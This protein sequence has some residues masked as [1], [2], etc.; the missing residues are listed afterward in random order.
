[1]T[2]GIVALVTFL[3]MLVAAVR[4]MI[5]APRSLGW[6][7]A[8]AAGLFSYH[9]LQPMSPSLTPLMFLVAGI[10]CG[11]APD[12]AASRWASPREGRGWGWAPGVALSAFVI[13][14]L[15]IVGSS[16]LDWYGHTYNSET[17][18]AMSHDLAPWRLQPADHLATYYA[19]DWRSQHPYRGPQAAALAS[20]MVSEHPWDPSS[21][22]LAA[23]IFVLLNQPDAARKLVLEQLQRFP[24]DR[25]RFSALADQVFHLSPGPSSE[26][27]TS[28]SPSSAPSS[29]RPQSPTLG[30]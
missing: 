12:E 15:A 7:A 17:S 20:S 2:G 8:L 23:D 28:Q 1:V 21:R 19:L 27:S 14:A 25:S 6:A 22:L 24:S 10:A 3:V 5:H 29:P 18:L 13:L 4:R 16:S 11:R 30:P 9:L 26:P